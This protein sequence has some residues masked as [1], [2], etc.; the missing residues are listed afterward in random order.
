MKLTLFLILVASL[1]TVGQD[2]KATP[3]PTLKGILLQQ[4]R[5]THNQAEWFVPAN[6]AVE[7]LTG[8]RV[9]NSIRR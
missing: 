1:F 8:W 6:T 3:E 2:Q 9:L 5:S 7:R 4:L